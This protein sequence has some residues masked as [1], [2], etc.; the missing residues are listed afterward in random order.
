MQRN[1]LSLV[2]VALLGL[3]IESM[4]QASLSPREEV[5]PTV[6][7]RASVSSP[8]R[9]GCVVC[10][11][12]VIPYQQPLG[13]TLS[14]SCNIGDGCPYHY[15]PN[16]EED[17]GIWCGESGDPSPESPDEEEEDVDVWSVWW[18]CVNENIGHPRNYTK[19]CEG[20]G[21]CEWAPCWPEEC[22]SQS[23]SAELTLLAE[24][25]K[26][27]QVRQIVEKYRLAPNVVLNNERDAIQILD[28]S[29]SV[30]IH[31]PVPASV[32][33]GLT[34]SQRDQETVELPMDR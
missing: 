25:E 34:R 19:L 20:H 33:K 7:A 15:F 28:C 17:Y 24:A 8:A 27:T 9:Y 30:A 16:F 21:Y 23:A 12:W 4:V 10:F 22:L 18:E 6:D 1:V 11:D 26:W 2:V 3:P 31:L 14:L 13:G 32:L 29:K 5:L